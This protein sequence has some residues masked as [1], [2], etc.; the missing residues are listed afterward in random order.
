V[1]WFSRKPKTSPELWLD[2]ARE[3]FDAAQEEE[4]LSVLEQAWQE[5]PGNAAIGR[6]LADVYLSFAHEDPSFAGKCVEVCESALRSTEDADP[7]ERAELWALL[8]NG[9]AEQEK[10][11]EAL[12][13]ISHALAL[14]PD[15]LE[16]RREHAIALFECC[17]FDDA[18][19]ALEALVQQNPEDAW[20]HHHLGLLDERAGKQDLAE[21]HF[22]R[23]R[24]L[25]PKTFFSAQRL[26]TAEFDEAVRAAVAKLPAHVQK[27]LE[28]TRIAVKPLPDV[29]ELV[30]ADQ[31]LSPTS[32]GM[33]RG[34]P[35]GER[36]IWNAA[37]HFP[38]AILLYQRNLERAC[39]SRDELIDEI[40]ITLA[41]EVGHLLGLDEEA[42]WE[43]EL[44]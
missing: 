20:V 7:Q 2:R 41:H 34:M 32:L 43:R 11:R 23:S 26:S 35:I 36:S 6:S 31:V 13:A 37:D 39:R 8:S 3:A 10:F 28:N 15:D 1:S 21:E 5:H 4:A 42:L 14:A 44:D 29:D 17:Q 30:T 33:F 40:G 27:E 24:E 38:S 12:T 22:T 9:L 25:D 18:R 19:K 16:L